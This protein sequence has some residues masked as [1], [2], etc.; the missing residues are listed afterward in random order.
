[1]TALAETITALRPVVPAAD[2]A[3]AKAF[4]RTL[5]FV[6]SHEAE[7]ISIAR[8]GDFSFALQNFDP[9]GFAENFVVHLLVS[10]VAAWWDVI[11]ALDL[12]ARHGVRPPLAPKAMPWGATVVFLFDP[13]GVMWQISQFG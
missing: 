1:M 10:D 11:D 6:F 3:A 13:S 2:Y 5:G 7:D 9:P 12:A 4:Y 8:M